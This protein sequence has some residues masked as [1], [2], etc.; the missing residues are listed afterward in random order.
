MKVNIKKQ[1]QDDVRQKLRKLDDYDD[2]INSFKTYLTAN[3]DL[4]E[5]VV[6][7]VL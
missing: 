4:V 1:V 2:K 3:Q 5:K 6:N 7:E